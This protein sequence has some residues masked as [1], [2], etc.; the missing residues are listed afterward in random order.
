MKRST[1]TILALTAVFSIG[2]VY[3]LKCWECQ[4]DRGDAGS[5]ID[6]NVGKPVSD[7][8]APKKRAL[9]GQ[10]ISDGAANAG[11]TVGNVFSGSVREGCTMEPFTGK[12]IP[13]KECSVGQK[14]CYKEIVKGNSI[15]VTRMCA[16]WVGEKKCSKSTN[17]NK[18]EVTQ[19]YCEGDKCNAAGS[20]SSFVSLLIL[21]SFTTIIF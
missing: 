1:L 21:F 11:N 18:D 7:F 16:T 15:K 14:V 4:K 12:E 8:F 9:D 10:Q 13:E 6:K 19:C 3:A 2:S 20:L 5:A 17:S